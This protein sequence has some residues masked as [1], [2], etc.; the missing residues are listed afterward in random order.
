MIQGHSVEAMSKSAYERSVT[1]GL[2]ELRRAM[3]KQKF[4]A[5]GPVVRE[6]L[7]SCPYDESTAMAIE[8]SAAQ[9]V[10]EVRA[11]R[12]QRTLLD[13]F[14]K[15]YGLDNK[16]GV[17]LMCLAEAL[18]R[19]PD[20]ETA[21][22]LIADKIVPA[23]WSAHLGQGDGLLVN[24][25]TWALMLTGRVVTID[26]PPGGDPAAWLRQL[27][28]KIGE[29]AVRQAMRHAMRILGNEFV[30]GQS[31]EKAIR[32]SKPGQ[33]YSYDMLG[34]AARD[35]R[36]AKR[37]Y[38][39]YA[40]AVA[41]VAG[42]APEGVHSAHSSV[43]VKLSALH[44][45]YEATQRTRV[46]A[47]L[48]DRI[49][50]LCRHAAEHRVHLTIDAEEADRLELSLDIF[51]RLAADES[52]RN[53]PGLGI[54]V[55]AYGKRAL[56]VIDWLAQLARRTGRK[57]PVRLVKGA[58]W[59]AEIKHAQVSGYPG[60][61]VFTRKAS[62][63]LSYLSCARKLLD[64]SD[65]LS[66]QFA[67][68]NAHTI[69]AVMAIVEERRDF[70][71]QRLHGMGE[72]LYKV[73]Q[74]HFSRFP[75]VR[76]YAPVG[77]HEDLLAYLV[78]RLL[79][80]GA[81][82]SFVNRLLDEQASPESVVL[83]PV[84]VVR[85]TTPVEHPAIALPKDLFGLSRQN[86]PGLDFSDCDAVRNFLKNG[87]IATGDQLRAAPI[88]FGQLGGGS[89]SAVINPA[90]M[91]EQVGECVNMKTLDMN[92]AFDLAKREQR[93]WDAAGAD[94]RA[95]ILEALADSLQ[96]N[97]ERLV[98]I[99]GKEA[100]KTLPDAI[101]EVRE[102]IDF[103]RY[104]AV[105]ARALL[106][107]SVTLPGPTGESNVLSLHGRGV[108]VCI[109]PWN[110]PLAIFIG[111]ISAALVAG[112]TVLAKPAEETPLVATEAVKL[113][114]AAGVPVNALQLIIGDGAIG[115]AL[116]SHQTV[117]GVAFTGS[118]STAW[119]INQALAARK[120]PIAPLIA[121]TGGQNAM[122]VDSTALLEQVTDDV[123]QSAF[124]SAGQRCSALRV[125]YLQKEIADKAIQLIGGAMDELLIGDPTKIETDVGPIIS[126]A[127][128][129]DLKAHIDAYRK[130]GAL[131]HEATLHESCENGSFV[132]PC[133]IEI[134]RIDEL[135]KEHFGP[136]LHVIRYSARS[137][138]EIVED[139][140]NTGFGLTFGIHSRIDTRAKQLSSAIPAGNTYVNRNMT[141]AVVGSQPF[142]GQ[143]LSGTG[144]KAGGPHY[145]YRFITEK[146]MTINTVASG[147]NADLLSLND[148]SPT[149]V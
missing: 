23:E 112:N 12:R 78:R 25:S 45:R 132:A 82:S 33:A 70:E 136:I 66:S 90:D 127:A 41:A 115:A 64:H 144:P 32:R 91:R 121:E 19:I 79:E 80:N 100:G 61:P 145:L 133:M 17:A 59:D 14:L 128:A 75:P 139:I 97:Q 49:L 130:K 30:L 117:T 102:A 94:A 99:L 29:P 140:T 51:E 9:L 110:F 16:E 149:T 50:A 74:Q 43:S 76:V 107:E 56:L 18:L 69:A 11:D 131:L 83:D 93:L 57:I 44:P 118:T 109:S 96:E 55:Q 126:V 92:R 87:T 134:E 7:A 24:A 95:D 138:D 8:R 105:Q 15:E 148:T 6:L 13:S 116:V 98:A 40:N 5:E 113:M 53:W 103:C 81:N 111:Q 71:F 36:S 101:A 88:I 85:E 123:I 48:G 42:I 141:G 108:F 137:L 119:N 122:I 31:I 1:H 46:L 39:D 120:A 106:G 77:V 62:T 129:A 22:R 54:V 68:H 35:A 124:L 47:E 21:D 37:Y 104:Y 72:A 114:H 67:T 10:Q 4:A 143:G 65:D 60:F 27:V 89:G 84:R 142:G 2:G 125:L 58:Y 34:E 63:D 28:N 52:I 146:V 38:E 147:G 26:R 73:A 3:A 135:D 86:S 20:K